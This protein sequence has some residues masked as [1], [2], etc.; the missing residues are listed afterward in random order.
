MNVEH[1][2]E[3]SS[4]SE[5]S[6]SPKD[7]QLLFQSSD[8]QSLINKYRSES[9]Y[10]V[11]VESSS[12]MSEDLNFSFS[13]EFSNAKRMENFCAKNTTQFTGVSY[14]AYQ[15]PSL[16]GNDKFIVT[17]KAAEYTVSDYNSDTQ[18]GIIG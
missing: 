17:S 18:E 4:D 2:I 10:L 15:I 16:L 12:A 1:V 7:Q 14:D 8:I 6:V 9:E 11:P 13:Q 3:L 5:R